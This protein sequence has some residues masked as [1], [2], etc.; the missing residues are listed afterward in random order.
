MNDPAQVFELNYGTVARE[1]AV[2]KFSD[3]KNNKSI[4]LYPPGQR[5][6][7]AAL[8]AVFDEHYPEALKTAT[9]DP[10][11]QETCYETTLHEVGC[12][13]V[14]LELNIYNGRAFVFVK[15]Y[16]KP[17]DQPL[18]WVPCRGSVSL[19]PTQKDDLLAFLK[20]K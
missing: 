4:H 12:N 7:A 13:K 15:R 17:L 8:P 14:N 19:E 1:G 5:K 3:F 2:L 20:S 11:L 10:K 6:L 9:A 16:F 18:E